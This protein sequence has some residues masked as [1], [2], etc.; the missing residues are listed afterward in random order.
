MGPQPSSRGNR[1]PFL[2]AENV[3]R[4]MVRFNGAATFQSRKFRGG[5]NQR[6]IRTSV[7]SMGPQPSSRGNEECGRDAAMATAIPKLQWGRNLPVAEIHPMICSMPYSEQFLLLQW[8]RN[9]PVAEIIAVSDDEA[10]GMLISR[11]QWGR[12]LPVAEITPEPVQAV[13]QTLEIL[14][15][16]GPQP[17]SR[18]NGMPVAAA[19]RGSRSA[20]A[21]MGPQP[22]SRGNYH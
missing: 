21:S 7:A 10:Q 5:H 12:N 16:M 1:T 2:D 15:S 4:L 18:G 6:V 20:S 3:E 8:G 17:S 19:A 14:A 13:D 9:L 22:S 11:L